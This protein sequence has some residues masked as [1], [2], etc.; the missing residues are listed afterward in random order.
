MNA[1]P[2]S[3]ETWKNGANGI[4]RVGITPW[5][6]RAEGWRPLDD[7]LWSAREASKHFGREYYVVVY[8]PA[9]DRQWN[10]EGL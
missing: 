10:M 5:N 9:T 8:E 2:I 4:Q 1:Q 6:P 3:I 7:A